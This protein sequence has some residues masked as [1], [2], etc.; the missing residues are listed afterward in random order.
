MALARPPDLQSP[1]AL[2]PLPRPRRTRGE[3][4]RAPDCKTTGSPM[5]TQED[6]RAEL[7]Q[8]ALEYHEFPTPG[9]IAVTPT[10]SAD[11]PARPR[12]RLFARRRRGLRGNRR[13]PRQRVP[14]HRARQPRRRRHQ[15]H[16]RTG[17][18]QHR[19]AGVQ[20]GDG[21]QGCPVQEVR[22]HRRVR[23]RDRAERPRQARR[24]HRRAR[25]DLRWHQPR[26]HQGA[27]LLL[28]RA[29]AAQAHEDPRVPRR[30]AR[31]RH[32]RRLG[33]AER[34]EGE[35]QVHRRGQAGGVGR[36]RRGA[37]LPEPAAQAGH[38]A[39]ATSG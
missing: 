15:R 21:G 34:V 26:G 32:R 24:L 13:R 2:D 5:T 33:A 20:A 19:P 11:Q 36:R 4:H 29:R 18:G 28:R 10:K 37:R 3:T 1:P 9:K 12:A 31:H 14:L 25:A 35:R 23:P 39:Q 38:A 7:R 6:K 22:G 16:R 8:A 17:P 27:G 30:P